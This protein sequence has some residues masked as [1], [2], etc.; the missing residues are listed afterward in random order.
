MSECGGFFKLTIVTSDKQMLQIFS[1]SSMLG[2]L[3]AN[4]GIKY[5]ALQRS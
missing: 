4:Q 2:I 5:H 3:P 1:R